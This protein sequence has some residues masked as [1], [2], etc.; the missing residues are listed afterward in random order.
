MIIIDDIRGKIIRQI[1]DLMCIENIDFKF[2]QNSYKVYR[3]WLLGL[4]SKMWEI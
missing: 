2:C 1:Y 4:E 3:L